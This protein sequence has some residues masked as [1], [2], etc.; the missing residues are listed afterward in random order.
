MLV[1]IVSYFNNQSFAIRFIQHDLGCYCKSESLEHD[2]RH[3]FS[4]LNCLQLVWTLGEDDPESCSR[5]FRS[6]ICVNKSLEFACGPRLLAIPL[7][8]D[9]VPAPKRGDP[10]GDELDCRCATNVGRTLDPKR[11]GGV[12]ELRGAPANPVNKNTWSEIQFGHTCSLYEY[13]TRA[14]C[15]GGCTNLWAMQPPPRFF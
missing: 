2:T 1:Q 4:F 12:G 13:L 11:G 14:T 6:F 10:T 7:N 5:A 15:P 9:M 3:M 8:P